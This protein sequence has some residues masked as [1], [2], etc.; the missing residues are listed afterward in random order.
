MKVVYPAKRLIHMTN[1][2]T[3]LHTHTKVK[4]RMQARPDAFNG[5]IQCMVKTMQDEGIKAFWKGSVPA[6]VRLFPLFFFMMPVFNHALYQILCPLYESYNQYLFFVVFMR[7][8]RHA[9]THE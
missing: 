4:V 2:G 8:T 3:P 1:T 6:L 5:P 7:A 9:D